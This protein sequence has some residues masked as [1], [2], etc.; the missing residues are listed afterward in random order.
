[1]YENAIAFV[2]PSFSEGFGMPVIECMA[3][4]TPVITSNITS[5]PEIAGNAAIL[6]DPYNHAEIGNA[7]QQLVTQPEL[8]ERL[9]LL[10]LQNVKRFNWENTVAETL[11]VYQSILNENK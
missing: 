8:V 11:K 2:C 5:L 7:I 9:K 10:G 3:C 6:V 1:L 4:G